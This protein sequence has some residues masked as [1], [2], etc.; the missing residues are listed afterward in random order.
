AVRVL[1][2]RATGDHLRRVRLKEFDVLTSVELVDWFVEHHGIRLGPGIKEL[3]VAQSAGRPFFLLETLRAIRAGE[4]PVSGSGQHQG[5]RP[6]VLLPASLEESLA[7]RIR[8]LPAAAQEVLNTLAVL[9]KD[10][11]H[12]ILRGVSGRPMGVVLRVP[13]NTG[14]AGY[15]W[16]WQHHLYPTSCG[17]RLSR[18]CRPSPR[19]PRA[20]G[21]EL[22]T[23]RS[24]LGFCSCSGPASPGSTC[25]RRWG[26][27][28]A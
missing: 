3:I 11:N 22:R 12:T 14:S 13:N 24:L 17:R 8:A 15:K 23:E 26:V 25:R 16:L 5:E 21:R 9:G 10:T 6:R 18:S 27:G 2:E 1:I 7:A 20:G 19:S 28:P 4:L